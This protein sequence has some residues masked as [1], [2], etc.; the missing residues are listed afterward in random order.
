[1]CSLLII[2]YWCGQVKED[3][4]AGAC[5][6]CGLEEKSVQSFERKC[7]GKCH[8]FSKGLWNLCWFSAF[9]VRF[10]Q[11]FWETIFTETEWNCVHFMPIS[12]LNFDVRVLHVM[13]LSICEFYENQCRGSCTFH[14]GINAVTFMCIL[15]NCMDFATKESLAKECILMQCSV[16]SVILCP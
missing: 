13:L 11:N 6:V 3:E 10:G 7:E 15:W 1:M 12:S 5:C 2:Y 16:C 9:L 4:M 14:M 8:A